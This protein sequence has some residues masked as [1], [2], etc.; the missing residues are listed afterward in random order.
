[1]N[2]ITNKNI[3]NNRLSLYVFISLFLLVS[4]I[5]LNIY[6][7]YYTFYEKLK[8]NTENTYNLY[9]KNLISIYGYEQKNNQFF[10]QHEDPQIFFAPPTDTISSTLIQLNKPVAQ[11]YS[12]QVFYTNQSLDADIYP[13]SEENSV[14]AIMSEGSSEIIL[15]LPQSIYTGLRYDINIFN[16]EFEIAN[17]TVSKL[18]AKT[19]WLRNYPKESGILY[20]TLI[21]NV[22]L[23]LIWFN[24]R[25]TKYINN[26]NLYLGKI[27]CDIKCNLQNTKNKPAFILYHLVYIILFCVFLTLFVSLCFFNNATASIDMKGQLFMALV[28][29]VV[30]VALYKILSVLRK[31]FVFAKTSF[32]SKLLIA[33]SCL[34]ALQLFLVINISTSVGWD[35][36]V[37]VNSAA[38]NVDYHYLSVFPNNLLLFFIIKPFISLFQVVGLTNFWLGLSIV[39]ILLIDLSLLASIITI[40]KTN[41]SYEKRLLLFILFSLLIGLS[42]WVIVP[43][44]DTFSMPLVS[45]LV[46][47]CLLTAQAKTTTKRLIYASCCGLLFAVGWLIKPTIIAVIAALSV[48][49][50]LYVLRKRKEIMIRRSAIAFV[51]GI[52]SFVAFMGLFNLYVENQNLVKLDKNVKTPISYTIATGL[53]E[54]HT[55]RKVLYGSWN[56]D[57]ANLNYGTTQEKNAKFSAFIKER[58]QHYGI[59][60]YV[61]FLF[62]KARWITSEGSFF[63]LKEGSSADFSNPNGNF[64]KDLLYNNGKYYP[65][66]LHAVNGLWIVVFLGCCLGILFSWLNGFRKNKMG[67]DV[68]LFL[69]LNALCIILLLLFV[70]GRSRYLIS[71]LPIFCIIAANGYSYVIKMIKQITSQN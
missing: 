50:L 47:F 7:N 35:V 67:F 33:F 70:E 71:F 9:P 11:S 68:D 57:V 54:A 53:A 46:L 66:W 1:M 42:P 36:D 61:S 44:S 69:Q 17:I 49:L 15:N 8:F 5:G 60:G 27:F 52:L 12:V 21:I 51:A 34:F 39:N 30:L 37:V 6:F 63:W 38:G 18:P 23:I 41:P 16:E 2:T 31:I 25:K 43:Y 3:S 13:Y 19:V 65:F 4:S 56:V 28:F 48:V 64:L 26:L 45:L 32:F 14:T 29:V 58:L 20:L 40:R 22:A 59:S 24:V 10:A 62:N 55:S